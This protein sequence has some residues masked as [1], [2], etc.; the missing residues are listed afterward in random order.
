MFRSTPDPR[1]YISLKQARFMGG[2]SGRKALCFNGLNFVR[3]VP[4]GH[5]AVQNVQHSGLLLFGYL[6][7]RVAIDHTVDHKPVQVQGI[8]SQAR[9][10]ETFENKSLNSHRIVPLAG[11]DHTVG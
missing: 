2:Q 1:K 8:V 10:N 7:S 11:S 5:E 6:A 9:V 3:R 4:S